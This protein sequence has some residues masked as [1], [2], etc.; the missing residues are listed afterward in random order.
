M[1]YKEI[2]TLTRPDVSIPFYSADST[3]YTQS[4]TDWTATLAYIHYVETYVKTG[5][6]DLTKP[7]LSED[8]LTLTYTT[9]YASVDVINEI[10]D[11]KFYYGENPLKD[12]KDKRRTYAKENNIIG[13]SNLV[14]YYGD[15]SVKV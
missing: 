2:I 15:H 7:S 10:F 12:T 9:I 3:H 5:K 4:E 11:D 13:T 1:K 6:C 8:G 14:P